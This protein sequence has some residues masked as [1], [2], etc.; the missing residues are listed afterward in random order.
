L[1]PDTSTTSAR[2]PGPDKGY[3]SFDLGAWHIVSLNSMC[4]NVGGCEATSRMVT[5][6]RN[7]LASNASHECTLAYFHHPLFSS[8]NHGNQT[9]M[10]PTW[11]VLYEA[12]AD[13][14]VNGHDHSYERF[15]PQSL[16]GAL[17]QARGIQEFVVGSALSSQTGKE[18]WRPP[19]Q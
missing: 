18:R 5:W 16:S 7:D 13:V 12:N 11:G 8:G 19:V 1:R 17:D 2:P 14:I 3:Y 6:L 15:A 9:K 10:R 4:E